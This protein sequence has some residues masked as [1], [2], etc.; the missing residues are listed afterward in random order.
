VSKP[1]EAEDLVRKEKEQKEINDAKNKNKVLEVNEATKNEVN[2]EG[3]EIVEGQDEIL[4]DMQQMDDGMDGALLSVTKDEEN[5]NAENSLKNVKP[6]DEGLTME[7]LN[8]KGMPKTA[9]DV[10][11]EKHLEWMKNKEVEEDQNKGEKED[12]V[13]TDPD[14]EMVFVEGATQLSLDWEKE[15]SGPK[16]VEPGGE[17][18]KP[19][20]SRVKRRD[21]WKKKPKDKRSNSETFEE[22]PDNSKKIKVD[23]E[24]NEEGKLGET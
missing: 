7:L 12:L 6:M 23:D 3:K 19:K 17:D 1:M 10:V 2:E 13:N 15:G 21:R 9:A 24:V 16:W 11:V 18:N 20:M 8:A 22:T 14:L 4:M 5:K